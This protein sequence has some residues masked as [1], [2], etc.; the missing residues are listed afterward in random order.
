[1]HQCELP[2]CI[3]EVTHVHAYQYYGGVYLVKLKELYTLLLGA[4]PSNWT[5]VYQTTAELNE[6]TSE[7][8]VRG[9]G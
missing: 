1:M 2:S 5:N 3:Q 4:V 7:V 8:G 9:M 6:R